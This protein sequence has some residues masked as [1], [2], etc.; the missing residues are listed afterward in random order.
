ML[1]IFKKKLQILDAFLITYITRSGAVYG[2]KVLGEKE[3]VERIARNSID[4][5][6]HFW[7]TND[8][9]CTFKDYVTGY[10]INESE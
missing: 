4:H 10:M 1:S 5:G 7:T 9:G 3:K 8:E 6:L 2:R